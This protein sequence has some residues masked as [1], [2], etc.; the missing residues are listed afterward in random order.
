M[1]F[2]FLDG[3][4]NKF[5]SMRV[6]PFIKEPALSDSRMGGKGDL[7]VCEIK[8]PISNENI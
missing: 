7:G 3:L 5:P 4:N 2:E 6:S 8:F 1:F